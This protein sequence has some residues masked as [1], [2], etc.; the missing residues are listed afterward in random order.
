M[1][2]N[3]WLFEVIVVIF[4][5]A[6]RSR[7]VELDEISYPSSLRDRQPSRPISANQKLFKIGISATLA[8]TL[9][10]IGPRYCSLRKEGG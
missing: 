3:S 4:P 7:S 6:I 9:A 5:V 1:C 8:L 10:N 2:E